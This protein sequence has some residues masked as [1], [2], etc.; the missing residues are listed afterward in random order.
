ME[1]IL[2]KELDTLA[3]GARIRQRREALRITR[4]ELAARTSM[5]ERS[6]AEIEY[7]SRS[8]SVKTL[9]KLKQILGVSIDYLLD[10]TGADLPADQQKDILNENIMSSLKLCSTNQ[11][12]CMEEI[13][14]LYIEGIIFGE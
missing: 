5:N 2:L 14:R 9:F 7:G 8:V 11:L 1:E 12:R 3:M 6:I 4:S 10:G 13:T